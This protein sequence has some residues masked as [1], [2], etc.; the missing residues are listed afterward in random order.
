MRRSSDGE[1]ERT[2]VGATARYG[3][4]GIGSMVSAQITMG[5]LTNQGNVAASA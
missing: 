4:E 5:G 1:V 2:C 3:E